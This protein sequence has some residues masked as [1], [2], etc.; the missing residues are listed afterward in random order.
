MRILTCEQGTPEWHAARAGRV[1]ASAIK[2]VMASG[3]G[4][5]EAAARRNYRIQILTEILTKQATP[6]AFVSKEMQWGTDQEP[7]ARAAYE[8]QTEQMVD[9][10]GFVFHPDIERSGAS[11]DSLI[12]WVRADLSPEG[13][14]EIKCPLSATHIGYILDDVVPSDYQPQML[15]QM[16][17]TGAKW[18]DF[19]S[20]DPRLPDNLSLFIKRFHRDEARI[21]EM[22]AAVHLFLS[23]VDALMGQLAMARPFEAPALAMAQAIPADHEDVPL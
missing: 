17:C 14:V 18:V 12:G 6:Q 1:T 19:V 23:E 3:K 7:Y 16:A 21:N 15:W 11:P 20:Y 10:V 2:N 13:L 5:A 8:V 4:N 9:R 22:T